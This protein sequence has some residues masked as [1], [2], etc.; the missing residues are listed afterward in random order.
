MIRRYNW[1]SIARLI[2]A[3]RKRATLVSIRGSGIPTPWV[4][5][6]RTPFCCITKIHCLPAGTPLSAAGI[7]D[8]SGIPIE[9]GAN[10]SFINF[11]RHVIGDITINEFAYDPP[12]GIPEYIELRNNSSKILNLSSWQAG[13]ESNT[14]SFGEEPV[15]AEADSFLVITSDPASSSRRSPRSRPRPW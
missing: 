3:A 11:G 14:A 5:V 15:I 6:P 13:D 10:R 9:A 2:R 7:K 4:S 8:L 12:E 1:H